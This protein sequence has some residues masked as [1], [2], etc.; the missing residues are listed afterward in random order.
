MRD[1]RRFGDPV[2]SV[3]AEGEPVEVAGRGLLARCFQHEIDHLDGTL[4][5][6]RLERR[7]RR[8]ALRAVREAAWF[9]AEL[10]APRLLGR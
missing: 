2:L 10:P 5:L 6:D 1:I 7:T 8:Q 4:Y 3:D 9:G